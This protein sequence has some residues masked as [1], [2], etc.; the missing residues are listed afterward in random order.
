VVWRK[1]LRANSGGAGRQRGGLGQTIEIGLSEDAPFIMSAGTM[2]RVLFPARGREGGMPG[3]AGSFGLTSGRRFEG[4]QK[5]TV[6]AGETLLLELP[7][8]GGYGDPQQ[9]EASRV[10]DD[11]RLGLVSPDVARHEYGVVVD[12]SGAVDETA[13]ETLRSNG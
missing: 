1:E 6:P 2:D 12:R 13:T 7:G 5:H 10:A 11:V 8:G 9:R 3:A 4:K